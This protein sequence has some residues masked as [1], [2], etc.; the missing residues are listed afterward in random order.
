MQHIT[1]ITENLAF[2]NE[3]KKPANL[4]NTHQQTIHQETFTTV[5]LSHSE[6]VLERFWQAMTEM[7]GSQWVNE[8]GEKPNNMWREELEQ[9]TTQQIKCGIE[10]CKQARSPYVPRLPQFLA[11]CD[12]LDGD[13]AEQKA[14]KARC[15]D[16][17]ALRLPKPPASQEIRKAALAKIKA[18]I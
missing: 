4:M 3:L 9:M 13:T 18:L 8:Y 6:R 7:Y 15:V 12:E 14:F 11:W 10:R 5:K 17:E 2:K 16:V 1:Q